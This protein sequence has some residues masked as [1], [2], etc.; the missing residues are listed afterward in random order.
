MT[1]RSFELTRRSEELA[2]RRTAVSDEYRRAFADL[3]DEEGPRKRR[4]AAREAFDKLIADEQAQRLAVERF[5][6]LKAGLDALSG[7]QVVVNTLVWDVGIPQDG[8]S[9]LSRLLEARYTPRPVRSAI[10]ANR[11]PPVP[12][13]VQPASPSV[14]R[15]WAGPYLDSDGNGVLEF[16]GES[17]KVPAGRWTRELNFLGTAT[18]DT[19]P[20]GA[21]LRLTVQWR[22]PRNLEG[23]VA[24]EPAYPLAIRVLRQIDPAGKTVASDE[25]AEVARSSAAPVRLLQTPGSAAYEQSLDFT[26]PA[27]GVYAV[28]VETGT[29]FTDPIP[30]Q[31]FGGEISPRLVV[32]ALDATRPALRTFTH[33]AAG[34]GVPGDSSAAV[35]VGTT[36]GGTLTGAGPGVTLRPKPD[37]LGP[38]AVAGVEGPAA[39]A[40]LAGGAAASLLSAGVRVS[41]LQR[42]VGL[43][44]GKPLVLPR[45]WLSRLE[46]RGK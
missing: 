22:E 32:T 16:A 8:L 19:L 15:V 27:D 31:R 6:R 7:S 45:E 29:V 18:G 40:G 10:K 23:S 13:W 12:V 46:Y 43:E 41:D 30:A 38:P 9:D 42:A 2:A 36:A 1:S 44:P 28:R 3:S 35:A 24:P 39:A 20:A 21:R 37:L 11:E 4:E 14:G 17:A 26:V 25:L 5:V 34:V 33:P